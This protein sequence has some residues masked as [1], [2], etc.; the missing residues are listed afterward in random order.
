MIYMIQRRK[1]ETEI[2]WNRQEIQDIYNKH[3]IKP[4]TRYPAKSRLLQKEYR[5]FDGLSVQQIEHLL[6]YMSSNEGQDD[7]KYNMDRKRTYN[8][9]V[10]SSYTETELELRNLQKEYNT[11]KFKHGE[12]YNK[13]KNYTRNLMIFI[14]IL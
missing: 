12:L 2:T 14:Q 5:K 9:C 13:Y 6:Q 10:V 8:D 7:W 4:R 3:K 1:T 11:S